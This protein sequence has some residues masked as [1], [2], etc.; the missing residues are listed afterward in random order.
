[1]TE[2]DEVRTDCTSNGDLKKRKF[3]AFGIGMLS[4]IRKEIDLELSLKRNEKSKSKKPVRKAG[5]VI[6]LHHH[7]GRDIGRRI[8]MHV[9]PTHRMVLKSPNDEAIGKTG[10]GTKK[11][12]KTLGDYL[13][14]IHF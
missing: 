7:N 13:I 6:L 9:Q 12:W 2:I 1:M 8:F 11:P 10:I 14:P 3:E 5:N 4:T